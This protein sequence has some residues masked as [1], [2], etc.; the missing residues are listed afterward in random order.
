MA[1]M[2]TNVECFLAKQQATFGT[3][4]TSLTNSDFAEVMEGGS[5]TF[6]PTVS[7]QRYIGANTGNAASIIGGLYG[8]VKF[9]IPIRSGGSEG[10]TG[11]LG[12]VLPAL[13]LKETSSNAGGGVGVDRYVYTIDETQS[14]WKDLTVWAYTGNKGT[15]LSVLRKIYNVLFGGKIVLD[16]ENATAMLDIEGR[17]AYN[18]APTDATQPTCSPSGVVSPALRGVTFSM[19]GDT[20]YTPISMEIDFNQDV[21]NTLSPSAA[22]GVGVSQIVRKGAR[23]SAKVYQ[24][25]VATIAPETA[26]IA[27]TT[28]ALSV[29]WGTV[30][31]KFTLA[32]SKMQITKCDRSDQNGIGVYDLS[33]IFVDNDISF[34]IDTAV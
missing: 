22:Y 9:Q 27:G 19:F 14:N 21:V 7:D 28:G 24:D 16:F 31:N 5:V 26:L 34:T 2:T 29:I 3:A 10:A 17:G 20:D 1:R 25:V 23:W 12:K 18:G 8:S 33:G 30:P 6:E 11:L 32:S 13:G 4:E 15:S